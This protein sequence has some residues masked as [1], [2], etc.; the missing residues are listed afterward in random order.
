[1]NKWLKEKTESLK[2]KTVAITGST[3]GLG[4]ELCC[5]LAFLGAD[6]IQIDRNEERS[7][8]F[9]KELLKAY[10]ETK[11]ERVITDLSDID[12]VKNAC[13]ILKTKK[14][15]IFISNAGAYSLPRKKCST[16]YDNVFQIN[17]ISPYYMISELL[18]HLKA[19]GGKAVVIGS[20][21]HKFSKINTSD[22]D[23]SRIKNAE[24]VYGNSKRFLMFS[25][26]SLCEQQKLPL[27]IAHPGISPTGITANYPKFLKAIIKYPMKLIFM[28]PK[29]ACLSVLQG[30]FDTCTYN[31]WIGPK[32]LDIWGLPKK[33]GLHTVKKEEREKIDE[34][35]RNIYKNIK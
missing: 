24:K 11:I 25:L 21:A 26:L 35:A 17:F 2:G 20:I 32:F 22:I 5:Y 15:D 12:S 6:L 10:P 31:Q 19:N 30:I 3:G 18:P 29:K 4:R 34:I 28:P 9:K 13:N 23:F 14:I 16:G 33:S 7:E 8:N 27:S 1:M